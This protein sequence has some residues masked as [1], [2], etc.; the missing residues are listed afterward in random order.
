MSTRD[1]GRN[2]LPLHRNMSGLVQTVCIMLHVSYNELCH[3]WYEVLQLADYN[4]CNCFTLF[5]VDGVGETAVKKLLFQ[6]CPWWGVG[7]IIRRDYMR[8]PSP[9]YSWGPPVHT[10]YRRVFLVKVCN[11]S[12]WKFKVRGYSWL[13]RLTGNA[14]PSIV[15]SSVTFL[16]YTV[17][18]T[19]RFIRVYN[20]VCFSCRCTSE[21]TCSKWRSLSSL[22]DWESNN[23]E[24]LPHH[25]LTLSWLQLDE[26]VPK[27]FSLL[28]AHQLQRVHMEKVCTV[29]C[30]LCALMF[31]NSESECHFQWTSS[32]RDGCTS[33][34][35]WLITCHMVIWCAVCSLG[36]VVENMV[37]ISD[38]QC[39]NIA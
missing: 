7:S 32:Q 39:C 29:F 24:V 3:L 19:S 5:F 6:E 37:T 4:L 38:N 15:V 31:E 8:S 11:N 12:I 23:C 20:Y 22:L 10:I 33:M 14:F 18:N 25:M 2:T 28:M 34:C 35:R 36:Q 17:A 27:K 26:G 16:V 1:W 13:C 9:S 21:E 30:W